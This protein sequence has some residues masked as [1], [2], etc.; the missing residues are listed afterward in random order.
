[1]VASATGK[2]GGCCGEQAVTAL[3]ITAI[4]GQ[5]VYIRNE[6]SQRISS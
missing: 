5:I 4:V 3:L 1:M 2:F 6:R